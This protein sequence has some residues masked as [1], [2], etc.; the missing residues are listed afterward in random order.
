MKE[1]ATK[2]LRLHD[3]W[4]TFLEG[5]RKDRI[6]RNGGNL[7]EDQEG[8]VE[9]DKQGTIRVI[10]NSDKIVDTDILH[11]SRQRLQISV[12]EPVLFSKIDEGVEA[13]SAQGRAC[14]SDSIW[15]H[16]HGSLRPACHPWHLGAYEKKYPKERYRSTEYARCCYQ[17]TNMASSSRKSGARR[18]TRRKKQELMGNVLED[19]TIF[20]L[21]AAA[22]MGTQRIPYLRRNVPRLQQVSGLQ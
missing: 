3:K 9:V 2:A 16:V 4:C 18:R 14:V 13:K 22:R 5:I 17:H 8:Q 10:P 6:R 11:G 21:Q 1:K 20:Y 7:K 15:V 12:V 19:I